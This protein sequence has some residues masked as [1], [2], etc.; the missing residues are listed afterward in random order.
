M[1]QKN[2]KVDK[3]FVISIIS[4]TISGVAIFVTIGINLD[5]R[6]YQENYELSRDIE[7]AIPVLRLAYDEDS[8]KQ[9]SIY[10]PYRQPE[11]ISSE[12][13]YIPESYFSVRGFAFENMTDNIAYIHHIEYGGEAFEL[14]NTEVAG[15]QGETISFSDDNRFV[16]AGYE[17]AMIIVAK[18]KYGFYYSYKCN[19]AIDGKDG[20]IYCYKVK[21]I[22]MPV[23]YDIDNDV[24]NNRYK[25]YNINVYPDHIIC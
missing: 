6:R 12:G 7:S 3:N 1:K 8:E 16:G 20:E 4:L 24:Y 23:E 25:N 5:S 10:P 14:S 17:S 13:G 21:S 18:S 19:L 22:D 11:L 2:K 9:V 15:L